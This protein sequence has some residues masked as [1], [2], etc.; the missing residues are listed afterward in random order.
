MAQRIPVSSQPR[1]VIETV[2]GD[3]RLVGWDNDEIR[4][5]GEDDAVS[6]NSLT[7]R[8]FEIFKLIGD[9]LNR[10]EISKKLSLTTS[11]IG[12][13]RDRIKSKLNIKNSSEL[14]KYAVEWRL[15]N[16]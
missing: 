11:T 9:G 16:K 15:K 10:S 4:V 1:I 6:L 8:E 7:D 5:R 14:V 3:L 12:T 2:E 13:Y